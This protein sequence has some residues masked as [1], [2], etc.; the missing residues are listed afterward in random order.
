M[1]NGI[2]NVKGETN[3]QKIDKES[4]IK[5]NKIEEDNNLNDTNKEPSIEIIDSSRLKENIID[6][7]SSDNYNNISNGF[8]NDE[9]KEIMQYNENNHIIEEPMTFNPEK[10]NIQKNKDNLFTFSNSNNSIV[11]E[12]SMKEYINNILETLQQSIDK[13]QNI[14]KSESS[15]EQLFIKILEIKNEILYLFNNL[16]NRVNQVDRKPVQKINNYSNFPNNVNNNSL[17]DS[18][19]NRSFNYFHIKDLNNSSYSNNSEI[20][21]LNINNDDLIGKM[22]EVD[23]IKK[24]FRTQ[25]VN[26]KKENFKVKNDN[27]NLN[28]LLKNSKTLIDDLSNKNRLLTTKLIKYKTLYEEK[29]F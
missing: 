9:D 15:E 18:T 29:Q 7:T 19:E 24:I 5:I 8:K 3:F 23:E 28:N 12:N 21:N 16:E 11:Q 25:I 13:I 17:Y 2:N 6:L 10:R 20:N 22:C 27:M 26:L 14:L 1:N 4:S